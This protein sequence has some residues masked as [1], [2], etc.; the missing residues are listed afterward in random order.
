MKFQK[1]VF[2]LALV[3][4]LVIGCKNEAK[5]DAK[6]ETI[7]Q[8]QKKPRK[9]KELA[10]HISGMTC[11]IGCAK[12]IASD[13]S[14]KEG[15]LRVN[16]IFKDSMATVKYDENNTNKAD[17]I[18]FIEAIGN[19]KMYKASETTKKTCKEGCQKACCD[20]SDAEKKTCASK[21]K[22]ACDSKVKSDKKA[23]A[24]ACEK[25]CCTKMETE[26]K[27]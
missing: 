12:K 21:C 2:A 27:A 26:K 18:T 15:V 5:K 16:V 13:L 17:L 9:I 24:A 11:E 3:S 22:K 4:F 6:T 20:K 23:C 7:T 19:G 8:E 10:L 1:I 14:K 25:K